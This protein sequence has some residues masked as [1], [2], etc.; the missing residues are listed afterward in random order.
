MKN[1]MN[2]KL[3]LVILL[4]PV[5]LYA[6]VTWYGNQFSRLPVFTRALP[7]NKEQP[8]Q[9]RP[10][11]LI[12]QDDKITGTAAWEGKI[13]VVNFFFTHCPGICPKMT[14]NLLEVQKAFEGDDQVM[15]SSLTVDPEHDST[16]RLRQYAQQFGI[17]AGKWQLLT[18]SKKDIY[19][20]A[21]NGFGVVATDGDGGPQDF[22][23][24]DKLV[25]VD[26]QKRIRGY[27]NGTDKQEV[28]QLIRDIK[29][30]KHE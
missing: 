15:I 16:L 3:V 26:P 1:R 12:N 13:A 30:L 8:Y 2:G 4:L 7:G 21:R 18:G 29:K 11:S 27:Y 23:H 6:V 20:L 10:F 5:S 24:S 25:L 19:R 17:R 22:I 9:V 14:L 28:Q